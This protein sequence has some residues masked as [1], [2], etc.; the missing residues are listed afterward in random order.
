MLTE[1]IE[2][3]LSGRN[4]DRDESKRA[5]IE[6]L[7]GDVPDSVIGGLLVALKACG[8]SANEIAGFVEGMR[9]VEVSIAPRVETLV[10]TCGTGGDGKGTFNISTTAAFITAA[11]GVPVAKHGNRGVSS[12][13]GSA[14]VLE[15]LGVRVE[16]EPDQVCACIEQVGI[17]FMFAPVFHPAMR[18]VS[19][20][21]RAL[22]IPTIFNVLGPLVNPAG[23]RSQVVGVN[24]PELVRTVG[25]TLNQLGHRKAFVMHGLDGMDEFTL[26]GETSVCEVESGRLR[27]YVLAPEDLGFERCPAGEL[28]GG[29]ASRNAEI[30]REVLEGSGGPRA[31]V[32]V[33][34][35]SFAVLAADAAGSLAEAVDMAARAVETGEAARVLERLVDFCRN[36]SRTVG[37]EAEE[38][39]VH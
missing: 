22:G 15:A 27:E 2:K 12:G 36:G 21:R 3:L 9:E 26:A 4:L 28:E 14:D 1:A 16:M 29:D 24:R 13:C 5:A 11:C 39:D 30:T 31:D 34:N 38:T 7:S 35:A 10:D 8:E 18:R 37:D 32:A 17:G 20:A 25:N 33:A 23:A 19:G 6:I